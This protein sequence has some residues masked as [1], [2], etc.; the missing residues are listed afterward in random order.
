MLK[1]TVTLLTFISLSLSAQT[2]SHDF[3]DENLSNWKT[4]ANW[5]IDEDKSSMVLSLLHENKKSAF[6]LCYS[7]DVNF[8]NGT[9][10]TLFRANTGKVDRGGGLM[11]RVQDNDNYYVARFNPLED[12]FRFYIVKDGIRKEIASVDIELTGGWHTMQIIQNGDEFEGYLDSKK[13]LTAT[14]K[15]LQKGGAVGVWTKADALTSFD[16]LSIEIEE[17]DKK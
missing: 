6:N 3:D 8:T 14:D 4:N 11:W 17:M 13:L 2:I 9:I 10:S 5:E 15:R 16:N 1:R 12:N 7:K